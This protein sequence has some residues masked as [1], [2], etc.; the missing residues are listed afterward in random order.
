MAPT[1]VFYVVERA[2]AV[3]VL[4]SFQKKTRRTSQ[5]DLDKGKTRYKLIP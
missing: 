2:T 5:Q 4:H 1:G 3:Y